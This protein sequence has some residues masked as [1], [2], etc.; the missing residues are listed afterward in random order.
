[1]PFFSLEVLNL[2]YNFSEDIV[3]R[4]S[5]GRGVRSPNVLIENIPVR[6]HPS[7]YADSEGKKMDMETYGALVDALEDVRERV[8][9]SC[10]A[11]PAVESHVLNVA[12][13]VAHQGWRRKARSR[14]LWLG[15]VA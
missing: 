2:K 8:G 4:A 3:I 5:A 14:S 13:V 11:V 12:E 10:L 6:I 15:D 7:A 1:M 9:V